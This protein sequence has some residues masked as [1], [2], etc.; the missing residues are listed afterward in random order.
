MP[1]VPPPTPA[2]GA[3]SDYS[4]L[5]LPLPGAAAA[6]ARRSMLVS[7]GAFRFLMPALRSLLVHE[8]LRFRPLGINQRSTEADLTTYGSGG[9]GAH[10]QFHCAA[11]QFSLEGHRVYTRARI[12]DR[13]EHVLAGGLGLRGVKTLMHT[14]PL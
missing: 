2:P 6:A 5:R 4:E 10:A 1:P 8:L 9:R 14:L 13:N 7:S 3:G 11:V 12:A